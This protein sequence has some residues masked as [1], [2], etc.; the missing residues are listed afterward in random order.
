MKYKTKEAR[1]IERLGSDLL[2]S[3]GENIAAAVRE[4]GL[5][6]DPKTCRLLLDY[7]ADVIDGWNLV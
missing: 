1:L 2:K 5:Q 6:Q 3:V 4:A 7:M